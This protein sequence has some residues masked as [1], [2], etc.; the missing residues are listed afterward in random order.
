ENRRQRQAE[1]AVGRADNI[2]LAGQI[3]VQV[4][5]ARHGV[6]A[7]PLG[8]RRSLIVQRV[9]DRHQ[10]TNCF[11]NGRSSSMKAATTS[12]MLLSRPKPS[13]SARGVASAG[14][15][16]E[17]IAWICGSGCQRRRA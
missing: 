5:A 8:G 12:S 9:G 13:A 11:C 3:L 4:G 6:E 10:A 7:R 14:G 16:L 17:T 1:G 2:V 15:Q